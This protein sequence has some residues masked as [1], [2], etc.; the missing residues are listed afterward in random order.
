MAA[1]AEIIVQATIMNL[2]DQKQFSEKFTDTNTPDKVYH[3]YTVIGATA[4]LLSTKCGIPTA[5]VLG[6]A[7][8]AAVSTVYY[9]VVS[10]TISTKGCYLPAGQANYISMKPGNTGKLTVKGTASLAAVDFI[11]YGKVT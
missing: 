6:V 7:I 10:T 8:R 4:V 1:T 5:Q 3:G 9:N 2:G 11:V